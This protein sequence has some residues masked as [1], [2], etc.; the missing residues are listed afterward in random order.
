MN[1]A[2]I[3]QVEISRLALDLSAAR[4]LPSAAMT[5]FVDKALASG[6]DFLTC[7]Q[8]A[9]TGM[10]GEALAGSAPEK[11]PSSPPVSLVSSPPTPATV[12]P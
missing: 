11:K 3:A 5:S 7:L 1:Y 12:W 4:R 8:P 9:E 6:V 2:R 10:L